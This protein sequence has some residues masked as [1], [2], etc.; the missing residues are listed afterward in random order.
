MTREFALLTRQLSCKELFL[1]SPLHPPKGEDQHF[2]VL[3]SFGLSKPQCREAFSPRTER[4]RRQS[5][6][7]ST[8]TLGKQVEHNSRWSC[9][10]QHPVKPLRPGAGRQCALFE[11]DLAGCRQNRAKQRCF[12]FHTDF[13]DQENPTS[14]KTD[15]SWY[16]F[17][18]HIAASSRSWCLGFENQHLQK[19]FYYQLPGMEVPVEGFK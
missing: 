4:C 3:F 6:H 16:L 1:L 14:I 7:H 18:K 2:R 8:L 12:L 13:Q 5:R 11:E 9:H 10:T 19:T 15:G 17:C